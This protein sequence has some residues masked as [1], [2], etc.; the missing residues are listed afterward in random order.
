[1]WIHR[2]LTTPILTSLL[3]VLPAAGQTPTGAEL[4]EGARMLV[5]RYSART[6]L[7]DAELDVGQA[8]AL[9]ADWPTDLKLAL[10]LSSAAGKQL[11]Q[12]MG[13]VA[14]RLPGLS[15]RLKNDLFVE[16]WLRNRV[17]EIRDANLRR[18]AE[19]TE[20]RLNESAAARA[21]DASLA[22]ARVR[23]ILGDD[24]AAFDQALRAAVRNQLAKDPALL[25]VLATPL[26][27]AAILDSR[28]RLMTALTEAENRLKP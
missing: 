15:A 3:L 17:A 27:S 25:R 24:L 2:S 12:Q 19:A 13:S 16:S 18:S 11:E 9:T 10:A 23:M 22:R 14:T 7:R 21:R 4:D 26:D 5:S 28:G 20:L 6:I 8:A 1:M